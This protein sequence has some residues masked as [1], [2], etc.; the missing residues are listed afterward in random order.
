ML[1]EEGFETLGLALKEVDGGLLLAR[2]AGTFLFAGRFHFELSII[3]NSKFVA[4]YQ[5]RNQKLFLYLLKSSS[6]RRFT[7][8][9]L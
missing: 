1:A 2:L 4:L 6:R 7:E 9:M 3:V 8:I 5:N